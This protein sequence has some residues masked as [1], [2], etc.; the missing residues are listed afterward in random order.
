M[1]PLLSIRATHG[2]FCISK[3]MY[4]AV[5]Q[6]LNDSAGHDDGDWAPSMNAFA[7]TGH[8]LDFR[9][10]FQCKNYASKQ[11]TDNLHIFLCQLLKMRKENERKM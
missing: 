8:T 9:A 11:K 7:F 4:T 2:H 5:R 10:C 3:E 6:Y 1:R